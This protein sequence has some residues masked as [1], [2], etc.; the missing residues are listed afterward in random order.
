MTRCKVLHCKKK[1]TRDNTHTID[2]YVQEELEEH[3][4]PISSKVKIRIC[5]DCARLYVGKY[6][7][8]NQEKEYEMGQMEFAREFYDDIFK[9][10]SKKI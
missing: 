5:M 6:W 9:G 10:K 1:L 3:G 7:E 2:A 4:V 8:D